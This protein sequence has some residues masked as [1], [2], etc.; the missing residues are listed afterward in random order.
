VP[1]YWN[2]QD[3][4]LIT[5]LFALEVTGDHVLNR[6]E[7]SVMYSL[8]VDTLPDRTLAINWVS[9]SSL[10]SLWRNRTRCT[11]TKCM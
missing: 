8:H 9:F 7:L 5:K 10:K 11:A 4:I 6:S 2:I 1:V 3:L